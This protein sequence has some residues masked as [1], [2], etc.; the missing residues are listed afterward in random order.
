MKRL[1]IG[2][3]SIKPLYGGL[4]LVGL[5]VVIGIVAIVFVNVDKYEYVYHFNE[6]NLERVTGIEFGLRGQA[7]GEVFK[8]RL[9]VE[10]GS[11]ILLIKAQTIDDFDFSWEKSTRLVDSG[12][13]EAG[14]SFRF[15]L[16][17]QW[18]STAY[19]GEFSFGG[20]NVS[21]RF[22]CNLDPCIHGDQAPSWLSELTEQQRLKLIADSIFGEA[23]IPYERVEFI[24]EKLR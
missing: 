5:L 11:A 10:S 23:S 4:L 15:S 3:L 6:V 9:V 16:T 24:P 14:K 22:Y 21:A 13:I 2:R 7:K 8:G 1:T 12:R 18:T 17:S 19:Q 20:D